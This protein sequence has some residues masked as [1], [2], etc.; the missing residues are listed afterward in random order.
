MLLVHTAVIMERQIDVWELRENILACAPCSSFSVVITFVT[1]LASK[2]S[3]VLEQANIRPPGL[4]V[5]GD[6][7]PRTK[8]SQTGRG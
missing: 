6:E 1:T 7:G 8:N 5:L 3:P 2:Q 4:H